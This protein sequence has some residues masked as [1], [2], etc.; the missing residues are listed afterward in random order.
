MGRN[1]LSRSRQATQFSCG[2]RPWPML[3]HKWWKDWRSMEAM[4][5]PCSGCRIVQ[6]CWCRQ[7]QPIALHHRSSPKRRWA[8]RSKESSGRSGP[9]RTY[10]DL[11]QNSH[12]EDLFEFYC[13]SQLAI[14]DVASRSL[15]EIG[16]ASLFGSVEV[17]PDGRYI[18]VIR[19]QRPFSY[20][21]PASR[22]PKTIEVCKSAPACPNMLSQ[23][24]HCRMRSRS[25]AFPPD[26][27][28]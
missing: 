15:Q 11:L 19:I 9:V 24:F 2:L 3:P 12:D 13:T 21:L 25:K 23:H 27:D 7:F 6:G 26:H 8:L 14:I 20:L 4:E 5:F 18:L 22:F 28:R 17:S 1:L 10:Q 16:P